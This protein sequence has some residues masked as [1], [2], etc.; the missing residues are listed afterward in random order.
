MSEAARTIRM[1]GTFWAARL[2]GQQALAHAVE[3]DKARVTG[4]ALGLT[5]VQAGEVIDAWVEF[6]RKSPWPTSWPDVR[7]SLIN[8]AMGDEWEPPQGGGALS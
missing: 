1:L 5:E 2:F 4:K 8:R 7:R 3:L 6:F